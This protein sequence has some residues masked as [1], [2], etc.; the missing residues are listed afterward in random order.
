MNEN[1][2]KDSK[3]MAALMRLIRPKQDR[4]SVV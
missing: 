4:K 1:K 3:G 2:M